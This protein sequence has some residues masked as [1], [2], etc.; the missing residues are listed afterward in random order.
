MT[1]MDITYIF[2][3]YI[4]VTITRQAYAFYRR[5]NKIFYY[6]NKEFVE[7]KDT[8]SNEI[9]SSSSDSLYGSIDDKL[10]YQESLLKGLKSLNEMEKQLI[11]EKFFDQKS[12]FDIGKKFSVSSQ[13]ISRRKRNILNRLKNFF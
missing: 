7:N 9:Y 6:E 10:I 12:D 2:T 11:Y 5:Y 3:R 13:M 4:S 1:E 8:E